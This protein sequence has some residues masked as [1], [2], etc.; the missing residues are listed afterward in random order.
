MFHSDPELV[1]TLYCVAVGTLIPRAL[2]VEVLEQRHHFVRRLEVLFLLVDSYVKC[3][4]MQATVDRAEFLLRRNVDPIG[5]AYWLTSRLT[6][7]L[8]P[9]SGKIVYSPRLASLPRLVGL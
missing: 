4:L 8:R 9:Q 7:I 6:R 1:A 2:T 3:L 5:Q